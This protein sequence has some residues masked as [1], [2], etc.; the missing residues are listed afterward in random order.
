MESQRCQKAQE[1]SAAQN[2]AEWTLSAARRMLQ[3]SASS[4]G[5]S[6]PYAMFTVSVY[7]RCSFW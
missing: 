4:G 3:A 2:E 1:G 5:L 6:E 7:Q